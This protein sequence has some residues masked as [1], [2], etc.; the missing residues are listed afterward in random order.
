MSLARYRVGPAIAVT[1]MAAARDFYE[2]K[3]GLA[4]S[5]EAPDG[6]CDYECGQGTGIHVFPSPHAKPS[7]ATLVGWDVDDVD[8]LVDELSSR[9]VTFEQ[10]DEGDFKTDERGVVSTDDGKVAWFKDPTGNLLSIAST[11]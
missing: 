3:L 5:G 1:D 2:R 6:G 10:Y 7:G 11:I 8:R 9:G 4:H